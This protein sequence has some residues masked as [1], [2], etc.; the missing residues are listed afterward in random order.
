MKI[1]NYF[2]AV[3][4][5]ANWQSAFSKRN[6]WG[7]SENRHGSWRRLRLGDI[8]FFYVEGRGVVG[9]G[10][11]ISTFHNPKPFFA[12][13]WRTVSEW[14]WRIEFDVQWPS[15]DPPHGPRISIDGLGNRITLKRGFQSLSWSYAER[16][17]LRC[18][19]HGA[20]P[21]QA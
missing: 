21:N 2:L 12:E 6:I 8:L 14:P 18:S 9:Y 4:S 13:D 7:L 20:T 19:Q 17:L 16:L 10:P 11:V 5:Y 1:V 15:G 3:G